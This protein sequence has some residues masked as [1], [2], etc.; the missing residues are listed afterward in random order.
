MF[1]VF[2]LF[3]RF[4]VC[5]NIFDQV[6]ASES[7][8]IGIA[9]RKWRSPFIVQLYATFQTSD[10]LHYVYELCPGGDLAHHDGGTSFHI[11]SVVL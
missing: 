9:A 3:D 5:L 4:G 10:K 2:L 6:C 7:L 11:C 1:F 8:D